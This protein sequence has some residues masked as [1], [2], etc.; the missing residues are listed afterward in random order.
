MVN[1]FN[2]VPALI[3][4]STTFLLTQSE[5]QEI[6]HINAHTYIDAGGNF[7]QCVGPVNCA[8]LR[9]GS[10][11]QYQA[12][13]FGTTSRSTMIQFNYSKS[14]RQ[15]GLIEVRLDSIDGRLIGQFVPLYTGGRTIYEVN[16]EISE[17]VESSHDIFLVGSS[18]PSSA[19][20]LSLHSIKFSEVDS[21][22]TMWT[23]CEEPDNCSGSHFHHGAIT[24]SLEVRCCSD[25][26]KVG[27]VKHSKCNVWAEINFS[28]TCYHAETYAS[29]S[30]I[31]HDNGARLCTK[32][33]VQ[34]GCTAG[35]S[36]DLDNDYIW[37]RTSSDALDGHFLACGST[38]GSCSGHVLATHDHAKHAV[39]CCSSH[40]LSP[41][42]VSE[43]PELGIYGYSELFEGQCFQSVAY[44][45]AEMFCENFGARLC[46][47][48]ELESN[49]AAGTGCGYDDEYVWTSAPSDPV[50]RSWLVCGRMGHCGF[51]YYFGNITNTELGRVRCCSDN[52]QGTDWV[53][54]PHCNVWAISEVNGSCKNGKT[55]SEAEMLCNS[56]GG[57]LCTKEELESGCSIGS[58][59]GNDGKLVWSSTEYFVGDDFSS[60]DPQHWVACGSS[61]NSCTFQNYLVD[62]EELHE[63]RC[64]SD[65]LIDGGFQQYNGCSIWGVSQLFGT[66]YHS[67]TWEQA[68]YVCHSRGARLCTKDELLGDCT[69]GS[70][71]GHDADLIWSS[72]V[73]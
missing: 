69:A 47:I 61:E 31:C 73:I 20:T 16:L 5:S 43:C 71:C 65:T 67:R 42:D 52:V 36:C 10:W 70:G 63:V 12:I 33:E 22:L 66:C 21:T 38:S 26:E 30:K 7:L 60:P 27:W 6:S 57:R 62:N 34:A 29:A 15:G 24:E 72:T 37:T 39:R 32:T 8:N 17:T 13:D 48:N 55:K 44:G 58:G 53:K 59:C 14:T 49:C 18:A 4:L 54:Y 1:F 64:C 25:S 9:E 51:E 50:H 35:L 19:V 56:I 41:G 11:L 68:Y 46:H 2:V 23:V 40:P 28:S 45:P 3:L